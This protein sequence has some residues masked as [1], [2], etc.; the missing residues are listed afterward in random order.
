MDSKVKLMTHRTGAPTDKARE[1]LS[2]K[3][4]DLLIKLL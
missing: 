4:S 1:L 3:N 2:G